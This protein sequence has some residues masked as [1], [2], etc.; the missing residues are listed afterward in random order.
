M[1]REHADRRSTSW[2]FR[3]RRTHVSRLQLVVAPFDILARIDRMREVREQNGTAPVGPLTYVPEAAMIIAYEIEN[4]VR[5]CVQR[6][7]HRLVAAYDV[8]PS[9]SVALRDRTNLPT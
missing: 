5:R 7:G 6:L 4:A 8:C 1:C 2:R 3:D 9:T